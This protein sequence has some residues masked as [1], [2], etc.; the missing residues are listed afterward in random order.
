MLP[1]IDTLAKLLL[2]ADS[3]RP[4]N[5]LRPSRE[6]PDERGCLRPRPG[7]QR[8]A[9]WRSARWPHPLRAGP[10]SSKPPGRGKNSLHHARD[11]PWLT[12]RRLLHF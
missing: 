9:A 10:H 3:P 11:R 5:H 1:D 12:K 6:G 7:R 4:H 8:V 2:N